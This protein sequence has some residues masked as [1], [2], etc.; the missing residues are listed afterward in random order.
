MSPRSNRE[1][2]G[3]FIEGGETQCDAPSSDPLTSIIEG[4][5]RGTELKLYLYADLLMLEL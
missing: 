5:M 2:S 4:A 3:L 1:L